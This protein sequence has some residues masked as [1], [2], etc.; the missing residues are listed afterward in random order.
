MRLYILLP[1]L[2][3][4]KLCRAGWPWC[5]KGSQED[6]G[7]PAGASGEQSNGLTPCILDIDN[8]DSSTIDTSLHQKGELLQ[9]HFMA[10]QGYSISSVLED[11]IEIWRA[12]PNSRCAFLTFYAKGNT[13]L[14]T[15]DS[16]ENGIFN[17]RHLEKKYGEWKEL[18]QDTFLRRMNEIRECGLGSE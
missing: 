1:I 11:E 9:R 2:A 15:M 16:T 10:K 5:L 14:I 18:T 4:I 3:A 12:G 17:L 6:E 13:L 7:A 8:P